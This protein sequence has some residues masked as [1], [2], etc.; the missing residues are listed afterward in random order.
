MENKSTLLTHQE[1][2]NMLGVSRYKFM[3]MLAN[4]FR[5]VDVGNKKTKILLDDVEDYK[6]RMERIE[7]AEYQ[8]LHGS[9]EGYKNINL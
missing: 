9:L 1:A 7:M 2:Y 6:K 5:Q 3:K 8:A 4:G